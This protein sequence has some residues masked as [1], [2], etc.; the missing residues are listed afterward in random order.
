MRF[1][2][3]FFS[4]ILFAILTHCSG[5]VDITLPAVVDDQVETTLVGPIDTV[6][7]SRAEKGGIYNVW[8]S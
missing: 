2:K 4:A 5:D 8:G 7:D 6:A 1:S 3:F